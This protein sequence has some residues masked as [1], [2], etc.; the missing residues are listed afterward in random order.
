MLTL[1]EKLDRVEHFFHFKWTRQEL[2]VHRGRLMD[3]CTWLHIHFPCPYPYKLY[4]S[5]RI[6]YT[7]DGINLPVFGQCSYYKGI[8]HIHIHSNLPL[9]EKIQTLLHEWAHAHS[10]RHA[11]IERTR[12]EEHDDSFYL[13]LGKIERAWDQ[14]WNL[15]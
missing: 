3:I 13:A 5:K 4:Q 12:E 7:H 1:A 6:S 14:V 2:L 15:T 11:N 10:W 8:M 9:H